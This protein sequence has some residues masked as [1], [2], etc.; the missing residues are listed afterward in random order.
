MRQRR[1]GSRRNGSKSV[2]RA[3]VRFPAPHCHGRAISSASRKQRTLAGTNWR[4]GSRACTR[5]G[6]Q[7]WSGSRRLSEPAST[8]ARVKLAVTRNTPWPASAACSRI[9][10]FELTSLAFC[11]ARCS[12]LP[13]GGVIAQAASL[14]PASSGSLC[15]ILERARL[16]E[17][18]Q[19]RGRGEQPALER[20]HPADDDPGRGQRR[21]QHREH[22]VV[23]LGDRIDDLVL[24]VDPDGQIRIALHQFA[25]DGS[26]VMRAEF[27]RRFD[28]QR[29]GDG[30]AHRQRFAPGL[31]QCDEQRLHPP[32]DRVAG[33]GQAQMPRG[34]LD[35]PQAEIGLPAAALQHSGSIW[36]GRARA[37]R[38]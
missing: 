2:N 3:G 24:D 30:A 21:F 29:A 1:R 37:R 38:R 34:A 22:D 16:A 19:Q 10:A 32:I 13:P 26:G 14:G 7:T 15:E 5:S 20:E 4:V 9:W 12:G 33:I 8:A 6:S 25:G 36:D 23:V 28:A 18:F 11:T 17:P 31:V 27:V 35:Q